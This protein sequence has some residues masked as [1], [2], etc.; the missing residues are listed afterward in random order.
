MAHDP[1]GATAAFA[2]L[3]HIKLDETDLD[4]VLNQVTDLARRTLPGAAQVSIT[5]LRDRG[6][7]TAAHTGAIALRLDELQYERG[8]G[9]CLEAAEAKAVVEV[10]DT[11][12]DGRWEGWGAEAALAG[13]GS[14]LS[15]G[16]PIRDD[17]SGAL[18]VYGA[19][20]RAFDDCTVTLAQ[21]LGGYASVALGNVHLYGV[22]AGL[23]RDMRAAMES[24][25]VIEQA[26]GIIMGERRCTPDEAFAILA[27]LSQDTNRKLR[28]VAVALV[29]GT[30][31][32]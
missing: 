23:A 4:G 20:A 24:R 17:V 26:K 6:A 16:L 1:T 22:T 29:E 13:M 3:G 32:G 2:E 10:P 11:A 28:D 5:L 30:Q 25:A 7:V 8:T 21:T 31:R 18:N 9:P 19:D 27:K 14:V 12:A 15:L